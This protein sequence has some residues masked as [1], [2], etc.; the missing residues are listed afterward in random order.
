M[1]S[2]SPN[3]SC[4][5]N[6]LY[7]PLPSCFPSYFSFSFPLP[8]SALFPILPSSSFPVH[9]FQSCLLSLSVPLQHAQHFS[10][11]FSNFPVPCY[12]ESWQ[13]S[14]SFSVPGEKSYKCN[15]NGCTWAFSRLDELNRHKKRHTGEQP[16]WCT[17]VTKTLPNRSLKAAS[18]SSPINFSHDDKP[19]SLWGN[20][21]N[22]KIL[23]AKTLLG[24]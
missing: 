12:L 22:G 1:D 6:L 7:P 9:T 23:P 24:N 15:V 5:L 17:Y 10:S 13:V 3:R 19:S 14:F 16:Y 20:D 11:F 18:E 2:E 21:L 8:P 4:P